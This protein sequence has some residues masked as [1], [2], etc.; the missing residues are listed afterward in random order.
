MAS[1]VFQ[2]I[3]DKLL[4]T[5]VSG[6]NGATVDG[7]VLSQSEV[8]RANAIITEYNKLVTAHQNLISDHQQLQNRIRQL[9]SDLGRQ[10]SLSRNADNSLARISSDNRRISQ[11]EMVGSFVDLRL[12]AYLT[13]I[14]IDPAL[15]KEE[16][17]ALMSKRQR[18]TYNLYAIASTD[19]MLLT[20]NISD[21]LLAVESLV[22]KSL[23]G[24][25]TGLEGT[26]GYPNSLYAIKAVLADC[27]LTVTQAEHDVFKEWFTK[28]VSDLSASVRFFS[29]TK[30]INPET[31]PPIS[32]ADAEHYINDLQHIKAIKAEIP[33][34]AVG[35]L[36][37]DEPTLTSDAL[38]PSS[39]QTG[40]YGIKHRIMSM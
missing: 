14:G 39:Y 12:N 33:E 35:L 6:M 5:N 7:V 36:I 25:L 26:D 3:A 38:M 23:N 1:E 40:A 32:L 2:L 8:D 15:K 11:G 27:L 19:Y 20:H 30:Q 28:R 10:Q 24:E 29:D 31:I 13:S 4:G 9:E 22:F 34:R 16:R 37:G 21:L 17:V 18:Y